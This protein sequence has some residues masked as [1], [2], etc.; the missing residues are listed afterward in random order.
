MMSISSPN[1]IEIPRDIADSVVYCFRSKSASS[2]SPAARKANQED[3]QSAWK[4]FKEGVRVAKY[5]LI[6]CSNAVFF[7]NQWDAKAVGLTGLMHKQ[8]L[9]LSADLPHIDPEKAIE[10]VD[11]RLVNPNALERLD[12][13]STEF[14]DRS[15]VRKISV[16]KGEFKSSAGLLYRI[17]L[18]NWIFEPM[19][20]QLRELYPHATIS[21]SVLKF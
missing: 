3:Q 12:L 5:A 18:S 9:E 15:E 13:Y 17:T 6:F 21:T 16:M 1:P 4:T 20:R 10:F 7:F 19:V 8:L 11:G 14:V 2:D